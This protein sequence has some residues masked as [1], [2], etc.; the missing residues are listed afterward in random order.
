MIPASWPPAPQQVV[1]RG[2]PLPEVL[3]QFFSVVL[4][5]TQLEFTVLVEDRSVDA[6]GNRSWHGSTR[7]WGS[8]QARFGVL[9]DAAGN[10]LRIWMARPVEL[11][12]RVSVPSLRSGDLWEVV[13]AHVPLP[14]VPAFAGDE[15]YL[16]ELIRIDHSAVR[17][18]EVGG[19]GVLVR[20]TFVGQSGTFS[21]LEPSDLSEVE[22]LALPALPPGEALPSFAALATM[23][24]NE[25][26]AGADLAEL[27]DPLQAVL[28]LR[29]QA[30][31]LTLRPTAPFLDEVFLRVGTAPE[32]AWNLVPGL[33]LLSMRDLRLSLSVRAPLEP[34]RR[35]TRL[36]ASGVFRVGSLSLDASASFP[37]GFVHASLV[38]G[39][40]W[41]LADL[42]EALHLPVPA[43]GAPV[44][45]E[46]VVGAYPHRSPPQFVMR[47][48]LEE[49]ATLDLALGGPSLSLRA[50]QVEVRGDG[51]GG[52][53]GTVVAELEAAG[54]RLSLLASHAVGSDGWF[55]RGAL[56]GSG[57]SVDGLESW[58]SAQIHAAVLPRALV[59][60]H[61]TLDDLL[62]S[63]DT[64]DRH[65]QLQVAVALH[66]GGLEGTVALDLDVLPQGGGHTQHRISGS[67]TLDSGHRFELQVGDGGADEEA[68]IVGSY[69]AEEGATVSELL[70]A[71]G[72]GLP[73]EIPLVDAVFARGGGR[74]LVLVDL[75]EGVDLAHLP[76]IGRMLPEGLSLDLRLRLLV[77]EAGWTA[78]AVDA[79]VAALPQGVAPVALADGETELPKLSLRAQIR[80]GDE[81]LC[82]PPFGVEARPHA[83]VASQVGPQTQA[84]PVQADPAAPGGVHWVEVGKAVGPI[85]LRRLG[86]GVDAV[87]GT[88]DIEI[89]S[90]LVMGPVTFSLDGLGV[91]TPLDRFEP[92]F[93]LRGLGL[94]VRAGEVE[95]EGA[96]LMV[97][98]DL[99]GGEPSF[100]GA[101]LVKTKTLSLSAL[102]AFGE[103]NG[104]KSLFVYAVLDYPLGGPSFFFVTGLAAGFGY[105]RRLILPEIDDVASFP[106]VADAVAGAGA[107]ALPSGDA[108]MDKLA[109]VQRYVPASVGDYFLAVGVKFTSFKLVESFVLLSVSFGNR[110]EIDLLGL[111]T[112]VTPPPESGQTPL[113]VVQVALKGRFAPAEGFLGIEARITSASFILSRDCHLSGGFAFSSWFSGEHAGDFALTLGGYHPLFHAPSHYPQ[114]P[115]LA[116]H[117]QVC[118]EVEIKGDAYYALTGQALMAGGHLEATYRSGNLSAWF[119]A[120]ADFL[121][122]WKPYHYD[123]SMY[124]S[125]GA[126]YTY[127]FL[128]T[129]HIQVEVGA[130]VH[131][132]GP[133]FAGT[134]HIDLTIVS[135]TVAFG[136]QGKPKVQHQTWGE[137][138]TS[139][140][141]E[142]SDICAIS[143]RSGLVRSIPSPRSEGPD[144]VVSAEELCLE[145]STQVPVKELRI[146][147]EDED[148]AAGSP[149][150][151]RSMEP[152]PLPALGVSPVGTAATEFTS[153][154]D[155]VVRR[156]GA[157]VTGLRA[158]PVRKRVPKAMWGP[159]LSEETLAPSLEAESLIPGALAGVALRPARGAPA[160]GSRPVSREDLA[161]DTVAVRD[162]HLRWDPCLCADAALV[163]DPAERARV[164][165]L[166][167]DDEAVARRRLE[168]LAALGLE[169][170]SIRVGAGL[171]S[172]FQAPPQVGALLP[173]LVSA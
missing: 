167:L 139:F 41:H 40:V 48:R 86:L 37:D 117:W 156:G 124:V 52:I 66:L 58:L 49:V 69:V 23:L 83:E 85:H 109:S 157:L 173:E 96:L 53:E 6:A 136:D 35:Q 65:L 60:S 19:Q 75:D 108:L 162:D 112:L 44:L 59:E 118:P 168:V 104:H 77:A 172:V 39:Q 70:S 87:A 34:A 7:A 61:A 160:N 30:L 155:V 95:V 152:S 100:V 114:V 81:L 146:L 79:L 169:P 103:L 102:G 125:I 97:E 121:V 133:E 64:G 107:A 20:A 110:F 140:L 148:A 150:L 9:L 14:F 72:L 170:S 130:D 26:D 126:S 106:L 25:H 73:I 158:S 141:P 29:V 163:D 62:I 28:D 93:R 91:Q 101:A 22:R 78:A 18:I 120:G 3:E 89:D 171:A 159:P 71:L 113:A 129:H 1:R 15:P 67:F 142:E 144:W 149:A 90:S 80:L 57:P 51:S 13:D 119:R 11:L 46:L 164:L 153:R 84:L 135:F 166:V 43:A 24:G 165:A 94:E 45:T 105:N 145:L 2:S 5:A 82:L 8:D 36:S 88:L 10:V 74:S 27:P 137:F 56:V 38:P 134:A 128:G 42:L 98:S 143:C 54:S 132:W 17:R 122:A 131:L 31:A 123:A 154:V 16:P 33:D 50:V 127:T 92:R 47:G 116:F 32:R 4:E 68:L 161:Y 99:P 138:A 147:V 76:W 115:R 63:F 111:S 55:F 21:V 12:D 151:W